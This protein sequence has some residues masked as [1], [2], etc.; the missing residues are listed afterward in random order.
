[1][2]ASKLSSVSSDYSG[3]IETLAIISEVVFREKGMI[4]NVAV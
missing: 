3:I 1:M 4:R 2:A